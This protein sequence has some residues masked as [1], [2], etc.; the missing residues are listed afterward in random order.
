MQD[1]HVGHQ[2]V[3]LH[4]LALLMQD[5]L[6]DDPFPAEEGPLDEAIEL[7]ALV[8]RRMDGIAH[9]DI[10]DVWTDQPFVDIRTP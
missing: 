10:V 4:D 1:D 7:L 5:V 2:L 9:L 3:V 6:G 8:C